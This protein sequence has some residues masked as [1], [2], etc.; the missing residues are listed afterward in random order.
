MGNAEGRLVAMCPSCSRYFLG[1]VC[2]CECLPVS[3]VETPPNGTRVTVFLRDIHDLPY[4][5]NG[6]I[7]HQPEQDGYVTPG[8]GWSAMRGAN[9]ALSWRLGVRPYR[10]RLWRWIRMEHVS[11]IEGGWDAE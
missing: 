9:D 3:L 7:E 2:D 1:R 6:T 4:T 8:G 10:R 11:R 5:I